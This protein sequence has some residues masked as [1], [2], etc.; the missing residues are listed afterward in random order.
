[1]PSDR[2]CPARGVGEQL[3]DIIVAIDDQDVN[4]EADLFKI[5]EARKPGDIISVTAQR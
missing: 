2:S 1:M 5:L 4:T 3:G